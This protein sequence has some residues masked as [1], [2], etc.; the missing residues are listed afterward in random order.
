MSRPAPNPNPTP[1]TIL[2][3]QRDLLTSRDLFRRV[4]SLSSQRLSTYQQFCLDVK[5][6]ELVVDDERDDEACEA[7]L[8]TWVV[9]LFTDANVGLWFAYWCTQTA[10]ADIYCKKL[11]TLNR[12]GAVR[13]FHLLDDGRQSVCLHT[14]R[15]TIELDGVRPDEADEWTIASVQH[16]GAVLHL[17]KPFRV[18]HQTHDP[19]THE[20]CFRVVRRYM[21]HVWV[22]GTRDRLGEYTVRWVDRV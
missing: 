12:R 5:R 11:H 2:N 6:L 16:V 14:A 18:A 3:R 8:Y 22:Y 4:T 10:L 17:T 9:N 19:E 20:D 7:A 21:L 15:E 1:T 13:F